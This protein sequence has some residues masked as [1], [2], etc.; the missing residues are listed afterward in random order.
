MPANTITKQ[1]S[2]GIKCVHGELSKSNLT[3]K[4]KVEIRT[5][6][7]SKFDLKILK[8][9]QNEDQECVYGLQFDFSYIVLLKFIHSTFIHYT[10]NLYIYIHIVHHRQASIEQAAAVCHPCSIKIWRWQIRRKREGERDTKQPVSLDRVIIPVRIRGG[11]DV[12]YWMYNNGK[13]AHQQPK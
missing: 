7:W 12:H 5:T 8:T 4:M 10:H 6:G 9:S 13:A 2:M 1:W 3:L 11:E